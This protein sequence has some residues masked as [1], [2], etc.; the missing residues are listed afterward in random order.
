[1]CSWRWN[2]RERRSVHSSRACTAQSVSFSKNCSSNPSASGSWSRSAFISNAG[3]LGSTVNP[4]LK[5]VLGIFASPV[6]G[7]ISCIRQSRALADSR[8]CFAAVDVLF[9]PLLFGCLS[10]FPGCFA[11]GFGCFPLLFS[12]FSLLFG[13][14]RLGFDCFALTFCFTGRVSDPELPSSS[15]S[16]SSSAVGAL[17]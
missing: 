6:L 2:A 14:F 7:S 3:M 16:S 4:L 11:L 12:C 5:R 15:S 8:Y 10:F 1:M 17:T 13:C 9:F